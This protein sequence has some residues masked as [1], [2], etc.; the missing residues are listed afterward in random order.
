MFT[1]QRFS[2]LVGKSVLDE[3]AISCSSGRDFPGSSGRDF[4][5]YEFNQF[6]LEE[7]CRYYVLVRNCVGDGAIVNVGGAGMALDLD[8]LNDNMILTLIALA[9]DVEAGTRLR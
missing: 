3:R 2:R 6:R 8:R 1:R 5:N 4:P 9:L 7:R